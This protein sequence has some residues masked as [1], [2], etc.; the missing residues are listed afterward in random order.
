V[1]DRQRPIE[2]TVDSGAYRLSIGGIGSLWVALDGGSF[3]CSY[4]AP[5][6]APKHVQQA[7]LGP[8]IT[9]AL[10]LQGTFCL[11][12]SAVEVDSGLLAFVGKTGAGKSTL[13]RMLA[14]SALLGQRRAS[15]DILPL[16][17]DSDQPTA[18]IDFPQLKLAPDQQ[19]CLSGPS[20][21]PLRALFLLRAPTDASPQRA[22]RVERLGAR[23]S[24][25][26]LIRH[27][28]AARLFD[29]ELLERHLTFSAAVAGR[30][31]VW[32]L[33]YPREPASLPRLAKAIASELR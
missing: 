6:V 11:H 19:P 30:I 31:P 26:A 7:L 27:T 2:C 16:K 33:S 10:A 23:D 5:G 32:R 8:A 17:L 15:D 18:Q 14:D 1:V 20:S 3:G 22:V 9:L 29:A 25:L 12:A 24:L 28:V 21:L 13:A 4:M